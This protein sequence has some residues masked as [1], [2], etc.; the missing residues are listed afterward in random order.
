MAETHSIPKALKQG[1]YVLQ[2]MELENNHGHMWFI[3]ASL[4]SWEQTNVSYLLIVYFPIQWVL[5]FFTVSRFSGNGK[6]SCISCSF[7][8][9]KNFHMKVAFNPLPSPLASMI[10]V[11][12]NCKL[13][14]LFPGITHSQETKDHNK[15]Q[16]HLLVFSD[17]RMISKETE[18]QNEG[19][20]RGVAWPF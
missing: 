11:S 17:N 6:F 8:T 7:K 18:K 19:C 13:C 16:L 9:F 14:F 4:I 3:P 20:N 12:S 2:S 15:Q 10:T 1:E 5:A